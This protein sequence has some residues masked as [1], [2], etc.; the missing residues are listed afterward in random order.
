MVEKRDGDSKNL[1]SHGP[2]LNASRGPL[3][4]KV[5]RQILLPNGLRAVL[6][7]DVAAMNQMQSEGETLFGDEEESQEEDEKNSTADKTDNKEPETDKPKPRKEDGSDDENS[8]EGGAEASW[9]R[10]AA[11]AIRVGVGSFSDPPECQGLA[12]FLGT[13]RSYMHARICVFKSPFLI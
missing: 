4:K 7:S 11:A 8:E 6:V 12:H 13:W 1:A 5:Y 9:L 2:D 10:D 3:D